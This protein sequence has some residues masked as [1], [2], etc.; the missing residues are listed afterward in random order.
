MRIVGVFH[1]NKP[2]VQLFQKPVKGEPGNITAAGYADYH[3]ERLVKKGR[4]VHIK[5]D[6]QDTKFL[7]TIDMYPPSL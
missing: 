5:N 2:L 7:R 1:I 3:D 4:V 6:E